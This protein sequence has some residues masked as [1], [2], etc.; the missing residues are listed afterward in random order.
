MYYV[1]WLCFLIVTVK[2]HIYVKLSI[3]FPCLCIYIPA[4]S[5]YVVYISRLI[6]Y[7]RIS[8]SYHKIPE[9]W[10]LLKREQQNHAFLVVKLKSSH[11]NIY[12]HHDLVDRY[13]GICVSQ[14]TPDMSSVEIT[15]RSCPHSWLITGFV[16]RATRRVRHVEQEQITL[17]LHLRSPW[18]LVGFAL[19]DH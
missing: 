5:A 13:D 9:R 16:T 19:L 1:C 12:G 6:L 17:L 11:R 18:Y 4:A 2:S 10:L 7:F 3:S 14:F 15:I 8:L